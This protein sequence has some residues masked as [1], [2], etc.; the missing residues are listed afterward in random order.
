MINYDQLKSKFENVSE[1][2]QKKNGKEAPPPILSA[3]RPLRRNDRPVT[4]RGRHGG[5]GEYLEEDHLCG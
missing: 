4:Q 2:G 5:D 1:V 3:V